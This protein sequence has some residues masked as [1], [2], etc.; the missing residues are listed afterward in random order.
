MPKYNVGDR[1]K[2]IGDCCF[3]SERIG[4]IITIR[5]VIVRRTYITYYYSGGDHK[6][7][8]VTEG[9]IELYK[10]YIEPKKLMLSYLCSHKSQ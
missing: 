7:H 2:V 9:D 8:Y 10:K 6:G 3:H 5:D 1:V 4:A